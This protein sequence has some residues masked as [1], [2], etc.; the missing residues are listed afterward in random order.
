MA[1]VTIARG[2]VSHHGLPEAFDCSCLGRA[3]PEEQ[4][5][6][7]RRVR[8]VGPNSSSLAPCARPL[9]AAAATIGRG[10]SA[11]LAAAPPG[12]S[13]HAPGPEG[14][15]GLRA[16]AAESAP[17][18]RD[19]S[20]R[21]LG[22]LAAGAQRA[23]GGGQARTGFASQNFG[24][25]RVCQ[26][27]PAEAPPERLGRPRP[28]GAPRRGAAGGH[29][30]G[31]AELLRERG[32]A[33]PGACLLHRQAR[34]QLLALRHRRL[35]ARGAWRAAA[36]ASGS[37]PSGEAACARRRRRHTDLEHLG[38]REGVG[39]G[40]CPAPRGALGPLTSSS[41]LG[42]L[43][44]VHLAAPSGRRKEYG[45]RLQDCGG[46]LASLDRALAG[47]CQLSEARWSL[48]WA[49]CFEACR[50]GR[51]ALVLPSTETAGRS[52]AQ[53]GFGARGRE[54]GS[55]ERVAQARVG[56]PHFAR[57]VPQVR[58]GLRPA[59]PGAGQHRA[60]AVGAAGCELRGHRLLDLGEA[61]ALCRL[62]AIERVPAAVDT[63][64]M[65]WV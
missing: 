58:A 3:G 11:G 31:V 25:C 26:C 43:A 14:P 20:G 36:A 38:A 15:P 1:L 54:M 49:V 45:Q 21:R 41:L 34:L 59:P 35:G 30:A 18:W 53:R 33:S 13:G 46:L 37:S 7:W 57:H 47:A 51:A 39:A 4:A 62:G 63:W 24:F 17:S 65:A 40:G 8:T 56:R 12:D 22:S 44:Q 9:A 60:G 28:R 50:S 55:R 48:S 16:I 61:A 23:V 6:A 2:L 42:V 10:S 29:P 52:V 19:A 5:T 27:R 64:C 32:R